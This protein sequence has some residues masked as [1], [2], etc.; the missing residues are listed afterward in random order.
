MVPTPT[1]GGPSCSK[2]KINYF[3]SAPFK[4]KVPTLE[5]TKSV[6]KGNRKEE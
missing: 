6:Y 4:C 3:P 5:Q 1:Q 2:Y